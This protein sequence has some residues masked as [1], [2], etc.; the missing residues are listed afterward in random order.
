MKISV[1]NE[2]D[3]GGHTPGTDSFLGGGTIKNTYTYEKAETNINLPHHLSVRK[4]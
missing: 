2:D 1:R 3:F 4:D